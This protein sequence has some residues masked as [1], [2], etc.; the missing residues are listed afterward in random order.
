MSRHFITVLGTSL[1]TDCIYEVE[2]TGFGYRTPFVQMAVLK[3]IMPVYAQGD[4]I[5][6]LLTEKS[7]EKNWYTR[8]YTETERK[9]L[10]ARKMEP[11]PG[12]QKTG[13]KDMMEKEYPDI[14]IENVRIK[15]GRNK[16]EIDEI[17]ESIYGVIDPEETIYFDF[18][19]GLR[20]LPMQALT[21]IH[22]AKALKKI[23]VGGMYYGAFELG[24]KKEDG[25]LH[26]NLL[27][28]SACNTIL[29]WTSA[30]ESFIKGGS[31][32]QIKELY[33]ETVK[34]RKEQQNTTKMMN[35]LCDLTN[36]LNTGR[37]KKGATDTNEKKSIQIAYNKFDDFYN[38]MREDERPIS[39]APLIRLLD[40]IRE[41][42]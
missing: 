31:S 32:N 16:A 37:G 9:Q 17:F 3:Y 24:E 39:E 2:G 14:Q 18:T 5:T 11:A 1:Y 22:Y 30:A 20:N 26:V 27:D 23:Q 10:A 35:H 33:K 36:C 8:E 34:P 38:K 13:L 41:D 40:H 25:W 12:E 4:R 29:D 19:H 21:V 42:V 28:M 15:E 6:V 7:E